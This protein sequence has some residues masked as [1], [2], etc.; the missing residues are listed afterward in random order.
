MDAKTSKRFD[1]K[2]HEVEVQNFTFYKTLARKSGRIKEDITLS[3]E[4][5]IKDPKKILRIARNYKNLR[6]I[7]RDL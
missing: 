6:P 1:G 7:P 2:V 3:S 4:C 5:T